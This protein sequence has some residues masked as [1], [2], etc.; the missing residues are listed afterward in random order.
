MTYLLSYVYNYVWSV[1][2]Y[3]SLAGFF[4]EGRENVEVMCVDT[5]NSSNRIRRVKLQKTK[6][7]HVRY[8][9][10]IG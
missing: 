9:S 5:V 2:F 8:M 4:D 3:I 1:S 6:S 7:T 10:D